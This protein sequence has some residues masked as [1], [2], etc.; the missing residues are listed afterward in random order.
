[1]TDRLVLL[2]AHIIP[3]TAEAARAQ[4]LAIEKGRIG[5]VGSRADVEG[6]IDQGWPALDLT[7]KTV[8][9]GFIDTYQH[10]MLTGS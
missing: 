10:M 8:L 9:P 5:M 2:G 4:A 1:V 6:L 7:G 3:M